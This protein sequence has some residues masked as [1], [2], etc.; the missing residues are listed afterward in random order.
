VDHIFHNQDPVES[1]GKVLLVMI[2]DTL[3]QKFGTLRHYVVLVTDNEHA[4]L[5]RQL[6]K[7]ESTSEELY[8]NLY[9]DGGGG[10]GEQTLGGRKQKRGR[11]GKQ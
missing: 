6:R 9:P 4:K 11:K 5:E 7:E 8:K 3:V 10:G 1:K 2:L